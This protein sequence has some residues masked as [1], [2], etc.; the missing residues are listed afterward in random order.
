LYVFEATYKTL[1]RQ[2]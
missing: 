2:I 1:A